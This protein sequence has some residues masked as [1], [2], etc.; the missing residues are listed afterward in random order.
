M[1]VSSYI[2]VFIKTK[3]KAKWPKAL[4]YNK[5]FD[6]RINIYK[7]PILKISK[8]GVCWSLYISYAE[9]SSLTGD[10]QKLD[11]LSKLINKNISVTFFALRGLVPDVTFSCNSAH[12]PHSTTL[13]NESLRIPTTS[14]SNISN[15]VINSGKQDTDIGLPHLLLYN[16]NLAHR[17]TCMGFYILAILW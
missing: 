2:K 10:H 8:L 7:I 5:D 6:K 14:L 4:L 3:K 9:W 15:Q 17:Y 16:C 11:H 1:K 12:F 13:A